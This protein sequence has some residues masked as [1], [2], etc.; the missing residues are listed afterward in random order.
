MNWNA[1]FLQRTEAFVEKY[2]GIKL[3]HALLLS[4]HYTRQ[5]RQG[6]LYEDGFAKDL[7]EEPST[8]ERVKAY[9]MPFINIMGF[10]AFVTLVMTFV[11]SIEG[12]DDGL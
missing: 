10:E 7:P 1:R 12:A 4:L 5:E 3:Q 6:V 2:E 8:W 11:V 9:A